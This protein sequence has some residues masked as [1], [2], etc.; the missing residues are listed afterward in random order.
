MYANKKNYVEAE[1]RYRRAIEI[2]DNSVLAH[3][4]LGLIYLIKGNLDSAEVKFKKGLSIDSLSPDGYFQLSNIYQQTGRIPEAIASLE[5]L[6]NV[7]PNYR[8]SKNILEMLKSN[9][10]DKLKNIPDGVVNN[11]QIILEKRSFQY[12][13][14]GKFVDAI[15][16]LNEAIKLNPDGQSGYFNNIAMCYIG[17]NDPGKAKDLLNYTL[18]KIIHKKQKRC[19]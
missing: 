6:Q 5:K 3:H 2:R 10:P 12:Y 15:K 17:M 11:Q 16:D 4:N 8:D 18:K 1:K 14:E 13:Q 9:S 19:F 7:V